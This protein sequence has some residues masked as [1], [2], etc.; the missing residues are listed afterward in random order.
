MV[1]YHRFFPIQQK[2]VHLYL[3]LT[4]FLNLTHNEDNVCC[5]L[6]WHESQLL[7][8]ISL[9]FRN[10]VSVIVF[11]TCIVWHQL[12]TPIVSTV[13]FS[14]K[15]NII[16]LSHQ[17]SFT[18]ERLKHLPRL[19]HS[20][21]I[22]SW[23]L[24]IFHV[25]QCCIELISAKFMF[26]PLSWRLISRNSY[27][28]IPVMLFPNPSSALFCTQHPLSA[29]AY[30]WCLLFFLFYS[31]PVQKHSSGLPVFPILYKAILLL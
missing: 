4:V 9:Y 23:R 16:I 8:T 13:P 17:A 3:F 26:F 10:L 14:L 28:P 27:F 19:C 7:F 12:Y 25:L 31:F 11:H 30:V 22:S 2:H 6:S 5:C 1:Q 15:M 24:P 21:F 29:I 20:H 18:L